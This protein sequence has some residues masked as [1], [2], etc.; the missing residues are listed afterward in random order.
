MAM[1]NDLAYVVQAVAPNFMWKTTAFPAARKGYLW[2]VV[3][4]VL[5]VG[6]T[7]T[8]Q[9]LLWRDRRIAERRKAEDGKEEKR[10]SESLPLEGSDVDEKKAVSTPEV[11]LD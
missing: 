6:V 2:S 1:G 4:Q 8:T 9:V 5:L 7:G 10:D 11:K 3:L